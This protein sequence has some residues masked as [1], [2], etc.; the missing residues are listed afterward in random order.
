MPSKMDALMKEVNK[1][2]K[3]EVLSRGSLQFN[4]SKIRFT[5]P[6]LNYCTYGGIPINKI[7]EFFGPEGG[8]K[9][10]TALDVVANFQ[11]EEERKASED[12]NY[13]ER[14]VLYC[15]TENRLNQEWATKIGV[16]ID[17]LYIFQPKSQSAEE[18]FTFIREAVKTGEICLVVIDSLAAMM[19]DG[20]LDEK[21]DYSD[22]FYGGISKSLSRF[23]RDMSMMASK[24]QCT[25]VG[26]NQ[27]REDMN[28]MWGGT[29]TPGGKAWK[30]MCSLRVSFRQGSFFDDKGKE[31]TRAAGNPVGAKI[32]F[33]IVKTTS[34]LPD[35]R[36]G[37]Y[38]LIFT[39]GIDYLA[40][41]IEVAQEYGIVEQSGAWYTIP[42]LTDVKLQGQD[43][44]K[45]YL[46]ENPDVLEQLE[47]LVDERST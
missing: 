37:Y 6:R 38:T 26:I 28:S 18:I 21:K 44:V 11:K 42:E 30:Y 8:G 32:Q 43:K 1:Q 10:T 23:A 34:G 2:V 12:K 40:D 35:R 22:Q 7:I 14:A 41:L 24:Y 15:D 36:T 17:K 46:N 4:Y 45:N 9:T 3:E 39:K 47:K 33:S 27:E 16:D 13:Q 31:L 29:K 20:E 5:S 25:C 19:S